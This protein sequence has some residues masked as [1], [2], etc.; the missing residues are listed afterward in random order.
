MIGRQRQG[1]SSMHARGDNRLA[2]LTRKYFSRTALICLSVLAAWA[3]TPHVYVG[4][5]VNARCLPAAEIVSRNSRGY[6]PSTGVNTFLHT[7]QQPLRLGRLKKTI[8]RRCALNVG[9]TEFAVLDTSGNYFR[10]DERGNQHVFQQDIRNSTDLVTIEGVVDR[11]ILNV[12]S[13]KKHERLR[14]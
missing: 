3:E 9:I 1:T 13:V 7:K 8:L 4:H 6:S 11:A 10:L 12:L 14:K 2:S 5:V